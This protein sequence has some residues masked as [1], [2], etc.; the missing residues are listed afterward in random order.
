MRLFLT[1]L[2]LAAAFVAAAAKPTV[3]FIRHGEK[4]KKGDGLDS[5]G[6]K[7]AQCLRNVFGVASDYNITHVMAQ[8]PKKSKS[9]TQ[10]HAFFLMHP[11]ASSLDSLADPTQTG[12]KKDPMIPCCLWHRIWVSPSTRPA[13]VMTP[14]A[15]W[16]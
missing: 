12:N 2:L 9:C 10:R 11:T 15:W 7:R 16:M 5:D 3:Y 1:F 6:V 14:T 4:P 13:N 8:R